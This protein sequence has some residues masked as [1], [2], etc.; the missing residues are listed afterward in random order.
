MG[1]VKKVNNEILLK[2]NY[3]TK[4]YFYSVLKRFNDL[5]VAVPQDSDVVQSEYKYQPILFAPQEFQ[6]FVDYIYFDE[7][8]LENLSKVSKEDVINM[9]LLSNPKRKNYSNISEMRKD[10]LDNILFFSDDNYDMTHLKEIINASKFSINPISS[11]HES[12]IIYMDSEEGVYEWNC[13]IKIDNKI[14]LKIDN[15]YYIK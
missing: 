7:K 10:A 6:T 14:Y 15:K 13:L 12:I 5:V 9:W 8:L 11:E 1:I 2:V 3:G 4:Q